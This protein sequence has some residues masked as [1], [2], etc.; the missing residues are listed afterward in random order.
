M[1]SDA[2]DIKKLEKKIKAL[3]KKNNELHEIISNAPIP[4]FVLDDHHKITHFNKAC[5]ELTG[6]SEK[7]MIGT[8]NQWKAFYSK[9]RP[10]MA[11][12]IIDRSSDDHCETLLLQIQ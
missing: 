4:I 11:D 10:V 5:E 7:E 9:R 3:E 8:N 12:L 1:N 6:L 2:N